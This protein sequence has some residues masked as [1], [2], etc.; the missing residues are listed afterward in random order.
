MARRLHQ[1]LSRPH[2]SMV[3]LFLFSIIKSRWSGALSSFLTALKF[4]YFSWS[5]LRNLPKIS[6]R[7]VVQ[8]RFVYAYS[9]KVLCILSLI[10]PFV[11][12]CNHRIGLVLML[13]LFTRRITNN[14]WPIIG[15]SAWLRLS[16]ETYSL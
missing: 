2:Y 1:N 12:V 7:L 16:R 13:S 14:M 6:I 15:L 10:S 3:T 5:F 4:C 11:M 9:K 8:T